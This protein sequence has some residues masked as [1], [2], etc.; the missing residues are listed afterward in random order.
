VSRDPQL[1]SA[2]V[3]GVGAASLARLVG[4]MAV[5]LKDCLIMM[6]FTRVDGPVSGDL[7]LVWRALNA[8]FN[9]DTCA[10]PARDGRIYV[11]AA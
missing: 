5:G 7:R 9:V 4:P 3:L 10:F 2:R 1:R 11:S 6:W 8:Y